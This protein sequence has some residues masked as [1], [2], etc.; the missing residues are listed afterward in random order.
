MLLDF[1][2]ITCA[3]AIALKMS[4]FNESFKAAFPFSSLL[5]KT[6]GGVQTKVLGTEFTVKAY[7][8][9]N[10]VQVMVRSGIVQV[11]DS[12]HIL[13]TLR[14]NQQLSY[15]QQEHIA[16]RTEGALQDWRTGD[17][18]LN[19]APFT[20]VARILE[21]RYGL[22]VVYNTKMVSAY[23]FT[24]HISKQITAT[25]LLAILK[26]ISGLQYEINNGKVTIH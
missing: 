19:N 9:S 15:R 24:L 23:T 20:E 21:N 7:A 18:V 10:E 6:P 5:A 8:Q 14:T 16:K 26:D 17:I 11:S 22:Q 3:G 2:G 1:M 25:E 13:D 12:T 4:A